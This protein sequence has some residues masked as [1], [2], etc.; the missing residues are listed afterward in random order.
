MRIVAAL[1]CACIAVSA[2]AATFY[3]VGGHLGDREDHSSSNA[4]ATIEHL[5]HR[6]FL[7]CPEDLA[8]GI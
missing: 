3:Y 2:E 4:A 5:Q 6:Q 7:P 8:F 1:F